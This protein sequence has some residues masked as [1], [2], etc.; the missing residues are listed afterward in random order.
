[1]PRM[2]KDRTVT[3]PGCGAT[4]SIMGFDESQFA[5]RGQHPNGHMP[6]RECRSC[7]QWFKAKPAFLLFGAKAE[8]LPEDEQDAFSAQWRLQFGD[9]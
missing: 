9:E 2:A 8:A 5:V 4:G 6:L 1:M 7:G 3:C